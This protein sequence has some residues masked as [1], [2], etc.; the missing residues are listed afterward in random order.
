VAKYRLRIKKSAVKELEAVTRKSD[1]QR[2]VSRIQ[3]L[4]DN[5]RPPGCKRLSG[6]ERYRI[7][8]G[9]YRIVY[10]IEDEQLTVYVVRIGDRKSVYRN[11]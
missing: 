7:R 10:A 3:A 5:P 4:A 1:R 8:Q 11:L 6:L 2:I 9:S